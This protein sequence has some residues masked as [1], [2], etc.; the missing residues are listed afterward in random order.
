MFPPNQEHHLNIRTHEKF[1]V[2]FAHSESYN[3]S[4][5]PYCQRLLNKDARA[6]EV[7]ARGRH[8]EARRR[9][10]GGGGG[11]TLNTIL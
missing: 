1:N 6:M 8:R 10:G 3:K 2:K 11:I 4:V 7:A 5:V 9:E